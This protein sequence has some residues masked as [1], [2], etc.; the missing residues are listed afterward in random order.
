M[1]DAVDGPGDLPVDAYVDLPVLERETVFEGLI[2]D[3]R[4][5]T[6]EY[7]PSG[8]RIVRDYVAHPGAVA[9]LALDDED[10]ALLIKQY[11]H[12][13]R[14]RD[15]EIPAGLLDV[16]GEPPVEAARRELAEEADLVA[17]DWAV[18]ADFYTTP[19]GSDEAIRIFLARG[20]SAAPEVHDRTD[21]EAD[22]ERRW[23]ALD[24]CVDA[25]LARRT[26]NPSLT[27]G[28]LAAAAARARG[29]SSL[30]PADAPW[31]AHPGRRPADP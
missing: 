20:L 21:E 11:R 3:L 2:W 9:I 27:I 12:P 5:D 4:R 22:M 30:A 1:T 25:V 10:R 15:W 24:D 13:V 23:V 19:G 16:A 14:A 26:G 6:L 28:V 7:G 31:P 8:A 29:W 17:S 18:L